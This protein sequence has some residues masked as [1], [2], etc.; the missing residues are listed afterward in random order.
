MWL[1]ILYLFTNCNEAFAAH[2]IRLPP[3]IKEG[4]IQGDDG[5]PIVPTYSGTTRQNGA[6]GTI[7][8]TIQNQLAL[9]I[10]ESK[11]GVPV[12]IKGQGLSSEEFDIQA[13]GISL[14]P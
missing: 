7:Q 8:N 6:N 11:P 3:I 5:D 14:N 4:E 12:Q 10:I 2:E 1:L 13:F 9:P